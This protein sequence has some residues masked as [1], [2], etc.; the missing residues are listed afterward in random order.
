[1]FISIFL[2]NDTFRKSKE[3]QNSSKCTSNLKLLSDKKP[4]VTMTSETSDR[5]EPWRSTSSDIMQS[6]TV[7]GEIRWDWETWS[8]MH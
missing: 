3:A 6:L 7:C 8:D 1:M 2:Q 5:V 4:E